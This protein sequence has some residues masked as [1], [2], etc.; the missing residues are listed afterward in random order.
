MMAWQEVLKAS[1]FLEK[2]EPKQKKKIKKLLQ[3]NQPT[4]NMGDEMTKLEDVIAELE[5]LDLVKTD[6]RLTKKMKSFREKNLDILAS[7]A[8]LLKRCMTKLEV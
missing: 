6:E 2:L 5:G 7:A 8:E 1:D 3:I 4:K